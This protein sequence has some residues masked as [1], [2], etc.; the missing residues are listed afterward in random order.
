MMD[1]LHVCCRIKYACVDSLIWDFLD[2]QPVDG[3]LL[4]GLSTLAQGMPLKNKEGY[5][6][7]YIKLG[8]DLENSFKV[9]Y[10]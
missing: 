8:P 6:K 10:I 1:S 2:L 3:L 9:F 5:L 4:A 7:I